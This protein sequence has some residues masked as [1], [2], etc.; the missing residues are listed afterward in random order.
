MPPVVTG[1]YKS[2]KEGFRNL[3][4]LQIMTLI[5]WVPGREKKKQNKKQTKDTDYAHLLSL[6]F[7]GVLRFRRV[8]RTYEN[9]GFCF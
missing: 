9:V 1:M 6:L 2:P 5:D 3:E 4:A 8:K 7:H